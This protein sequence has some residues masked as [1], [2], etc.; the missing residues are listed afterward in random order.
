MIKTKQAQLTTRK[1]ELQLYRPL[2][3]PTHKKQQ[4]KKKINRNNMLVLNIMTT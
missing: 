2:W 4:N 3:N 1:A